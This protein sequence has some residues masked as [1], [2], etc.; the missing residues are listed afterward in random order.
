MTRIAHDLHALDGDP[1]MSRRL[2]HGLRL[3]DASACYRESN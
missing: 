1:A 3:Q 2:F